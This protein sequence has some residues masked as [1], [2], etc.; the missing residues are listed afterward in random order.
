MASAFQDVRVIDLT[1]G[2][3][4]AMAAMLLA[5]FGA[6]VLRIT[7]PDGAGA[8][9]T[10]GEAG[11]NRNK[12][13]LDLALARPKDRSRFEA[14]LTGADVLVFD[15]GPAA[16]ARLGLDAEDMIARN[17]RLIALWTPAF[18]SSGATLTNLTSAY[19]A[20]EI[21]LVNGSSGTSA[22]ALSFG[23]AGLIAPR[24]LLL[25][26]LNGN[27]ASGRIDVSGLTVDTNANP[28]TSALSG[29][30]NGFGGPIAASV[31]QVTLVPR[32]NLQ[33]NGCPITATDC[34]LLSVFV[35]Q[36]YHLFDDIRV[37]NPVTQEEEDFELPNVAQEEF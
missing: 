26:A 6:D 27:A 22:P 1:S 13:R 12:H 8:A 36:V 16:C 19:A 18:G 37:F 24:G 28:G 9:E 4:G 34:V 33:L 11:W 20:M 7:D 14:L 23:N 30:V 35:P 25:L 10:P 21:D 2:M 17:P 31:G 3:A 15:H 29:E 5:D 32:Q